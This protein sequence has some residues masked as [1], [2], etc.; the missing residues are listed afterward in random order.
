MRLEGKRGRQAKNTPKSALLLTF[1]GNNPWFVGSLNFSLHSVE[2][3]GSGCSNSDQ[4]EAKKAKEEPCSAAAG[5]IAGLGDAEGSE[6]GRGK[7]F[8]ESHGLMVRGRDGGG[9]IFGGLQG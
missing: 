8:E 5:L 7:R 6:E 3:Y 9:T 2:N 1:Y 4:S